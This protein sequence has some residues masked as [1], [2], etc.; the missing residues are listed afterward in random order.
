MG[1]KV[2]NMD[3]SGMTST[4]LSVFIAS[5]QKQQQEKEKDEKKI[6]YEK[7]MADYLSNTEQQLKKM[8]KD[9]V[10]AR[11]MELEKIIWKQ[12]NP[13]HQPEPSVAKKTA[14]KARGKSNRPKFTQE[15]IFKEGQCGARVGTKPKDFRQCPMMSECGL[16][17]K[18]QGQ[19]HGADKDGGDNYKLRNGWWSVCGC[20]SNNSSGYGDNHQVWSGKQYWGDGPLCDNRPEYVKKKYPLGQTAQI[21]A[22]EEEAEEKSSSEEE[23]SEEE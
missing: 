10:I 17:P 2:A 11:C 1:S 9:V 4:E 15:E 7:K 14:T 21:K 20:D 18:H 12:K 22:E 5:V 23:E 6:A 19:Y 13:E 3:F 8:N 16:C